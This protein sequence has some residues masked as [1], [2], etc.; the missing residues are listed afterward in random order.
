LRSNASA[1]DCRVQKT[2]YCHA[3][4]WNG[5]GLP[6]KPAHL[7]LERFSAELLCVSRK[8]ASSPW[9]A[10]LK[11]VRLVSAAERAKHLKKPQKDMRAAYY[12]EF[13]LDEFHDHS[14]RDVSSLVPTRFSG[15][16]FCN[17]ADLV[18]CK[19]INDG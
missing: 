15:P 8:G 2:C 16:I 12:I 14:A 19:A 18:R 3:I 13:V 11:S 9:I 4:E 1:S 6:G 7:D 10:T 17:L 5:A